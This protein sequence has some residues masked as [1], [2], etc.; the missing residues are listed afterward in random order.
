[1]ATGMTRRGFVSAA[2]ALLAQRSRSKPNILLLMSD[3]HRG[4]TMG[5]AGH[6]A[7]RTP[8]LDR[9]AREGCRFTAAYSSTPTCTPARNG[10]LTGCSP[11]VHG[12]LGYG[13][14]SQR[15]LFEMPRM[16]REAGYHTFGIGKMHWTP[17]RHLHGFHDTLLDE[18]GR[19]ESP[20]FRSDYRAWFRSQA[21]NLDPDAT[22]IGWNDFEAKPY[23]LPEELHPTRWTGDAAVRFL[24]GYE[25]PEPFFL[26]VSF[27]RPHSP[28][29]PPKR[30]WDRYAEA[31]IPAA[32]V[33]GWAG[34]YAA[35]SSD[36]AD[37]WHGDLG[38]AQVRRSR[39][40]YYGAVS[41]VDEQIGRI[42][43]TLRK[44]GWMEETLILYTSD[45][46]DMTGDHHL[47]RK[48]YAYEASARIPMLV[49]APGA[50]PAV[51]AAPVEIRDI[52]PTFLEAARAS[53]PDG[54][55]GRSLL[56]LTQG[57]EEGWREFID[58][59]HDVCYDRKNHWCALTDGRMKYIHHALDGEEQLFDLTR[60]AG[61]VNDLAG[62][63]AQ[64]GELARW[65]GRMIEHLAVRGERFVK[66]GRLQTRA[67][68]Y[69][70]SP[71]YRT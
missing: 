43:E 4:D 12:M 52:L 1:M 42:L 44:R 69:L 64:G 38:A 9:L 26:K 17:Q 27:A 13:R 28:F 36:R 30:H 66:A 57:R 61:E 3:Q 45:H 68:S 7:V 55:D 6:P 18:S 60:D 58:L 35:R 31:R 5:A 62:V 20:E 54:M 67:E 10:L 59:E 34:R 41:F 47:W 63:A 15:P 39:Q 24:A 2:P 14:V 53:R 46:G 29:D 56:P 40:G 32:A 50:R 11:W 21:P 51:S 49:R 23:A 37:V 65:R 8:N 70:Y 22:G 71:N 16:L 33:G 25:R 19:V 48:S